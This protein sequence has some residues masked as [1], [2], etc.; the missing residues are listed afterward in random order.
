M[1]LEKLAREAGVKGGQGRSGAEMVFSA[2]VVL[3]GLTAIF[4]ALI[5]AG[6]TACLKV[7]RR[8]TR[9]ERRVTYR[10][11]SSVLDGT[12]RLPEGFFDGAELVHC[13]AAAQK[14]ELKRR[15]RS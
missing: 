8:L 9:P 5:I 15:R 11:L 1:D 3:T 14:I 13:H 4:M 2:L 12:I 7:L 10:V 6:V